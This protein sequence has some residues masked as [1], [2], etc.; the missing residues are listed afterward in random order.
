[1]PKKI[2]SNTTRQYLES[3]IWYT[4]RLNEIT[5]NLK[6]LSKMIIEFYLKEQRQNIDNVNELIS[7]TKKIVKTGRGLCDSLKEANKKC[8]DG[9][10]TSLDNYIKELERLAEINSDLDLVYVSI[11]KNTTIS[12]LLRSLSKPK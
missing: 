6:V 5:P 8:K 12:S 7:K 9:F 3:V 2:N 10:K 1:M 4:K 11:P